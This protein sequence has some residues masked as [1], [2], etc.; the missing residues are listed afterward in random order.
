MSQQARYFAAGDTN[1]NTGPIRLAEALDHAT[2]DRPEPRAA[3]VVGERDLVEVLGGQLV[4]SAA[5]V[6][7]VLDQDERGSAP[8][9]S[10]R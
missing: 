6:G 8:S 9:C 3:G 4:A 1:L 7:I 10:G 5:R 2:L